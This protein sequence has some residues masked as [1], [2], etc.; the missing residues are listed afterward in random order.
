MGRAGHARPGLL[1]HLCDDRAGRQRRD[2]ENHFIF[3]TASEKNAGIEA[4]AVFP[5]AGTS[6]RPDKD[7]RH[8]VIDGAMLDRVLQI[9]RMER[10][11]RLEARSIR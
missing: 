1:V 10:A 4:H 6:T 3:R 8:V 7:D 9:H 2:D 5:G 11:R